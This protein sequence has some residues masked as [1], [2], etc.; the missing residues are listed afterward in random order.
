M[1]TRSCEA[2]APCPL[3]CGS[4]QFGSWGQCSVS[5]GAGVKIRQRR[6]VKNNDDGSQECQ[7]DVQEEL[8][9]MEECE[10]E[11]TTLQSGKDF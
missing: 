8:C 4:G 6:I 7:D 3:D 10:M 11:T 5:C 9:E 1:E 2:S